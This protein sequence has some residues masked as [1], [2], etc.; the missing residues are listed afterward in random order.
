MQTYANIKCLFEIEEKNVCFGFFSAQK[1]FLQKIV[2]V[3]EFI[4]FLLR[5]LLKALPLFMRSI[6]AAIL[7]F[8]RVSLFIRY[9]TSQDFAEIKSPK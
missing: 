2:M 8:S 1:K 6:S 3:T 7:Q 9:L 4:N 5:K